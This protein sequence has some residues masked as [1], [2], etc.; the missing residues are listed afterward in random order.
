MLAASRK[1]SVMGRRRI[2]AVSI[3]MS[4]GLSHAGAPEGNREAAK[5]E[6]ELITEETM[7]ASHIGSPRLSVNRRC[8]VGPK[9]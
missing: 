5:Y 7:R 2:L 3:M 1:D 9:T 4:G 6:G 8:L